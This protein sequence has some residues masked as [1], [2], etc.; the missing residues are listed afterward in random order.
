MTDRGNIDDVLEF[1]FGEIGTDG[2]PS[3]DRPK[4]WWRGSKRLD[5]TI[6]RRFG[7]RLEAAAGRELSSW[8]TSPRGRLAVII[9]LDQFSRN[10]FRG[11][12]KAFAQDG[13]ALELAR[14][15]LDKGHDA[16]LRAIEAVFMYVPFM[17][18]ETAAC[19]S[20]SIECFQNLRTRCGDAIRSAIDSNVDF[21]RKHKAIID[22]FGRYPHRNA[23]L[24]R[25]STTEE[26]EFLTRP[27][28]SF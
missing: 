3:P 4:M 5:A 17:H 1:W 12:P 18:G 21:A 26:T 11:T 25:T 15:G 16:Q 23:I 2:L 22:R 19:Q 13:L 28:S 14:V 24:G 7:A 27:G 20:Q 10:I 8:L 6:S 9:L